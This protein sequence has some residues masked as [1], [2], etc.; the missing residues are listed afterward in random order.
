MCLVRNQYRIRLYFL[1]IVLS[2]FFLNL[3]S[4]PEPF[5]EP[6]TETIIPQPIPEVSVSPDGKANSNYP[7]LMPPA[8]K[9]LAPS[10]SLVYNSSAGTSMLGV[11]WD[12]EGIPVIA[13]DASYG[14][15]YNS[16]D[17]FVSSIGGQL[18]LSTGNTY[19][20]KYESFLRY[21][22]MGNS[23]NDYWLVTDRNGTKYY[24]GDTS[25]LVFIQSGRCIWKLL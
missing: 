10:L 20:T 1:F 17:R 24:F 15:H 13:R 19:Y 7:I 6:P 9:D 14:I 16:N 4:I 3:V 8:T 21:Q 23:S 2:F 18:V 5:P 11:G 22:K 25:D 12:L